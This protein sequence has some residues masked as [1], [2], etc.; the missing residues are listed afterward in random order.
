MTRIKGKNKNRDKGGPRKE[1]DRNIILYIRE[2]D[3]IPRKKSLSG[4]SKPRH[5]EPERCQGAVERLLPR[6][7]K[8]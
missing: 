6:P 4:N 7:I 2:I 1:I 5:S 3:I 8:V